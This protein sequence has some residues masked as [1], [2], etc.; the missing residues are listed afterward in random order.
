[1]RDLFSQFTYVSVTLIREHQLDLK[2]LT[3]IYLATGISIHWLTD[4]F[5]SKNDFYALQLHSSTTT[6]AS[7]HTRSNY[8]NFLIAQ[9]IYLIILS[10]S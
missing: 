7:Y 4:I 10:P 9:T 8:L 3:N 5:A 6:V 1:M 2:Y